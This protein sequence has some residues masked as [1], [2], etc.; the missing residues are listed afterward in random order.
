[1][2]MARRMSWA[3]LS[4]IV[5]LRMASMTLMS[6]TWIAASLSRRAMGEMALSLRL[7]TR[8]VM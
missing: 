7:L 6:E 1:M 3:R 5:P 8:L 2:A 4:S